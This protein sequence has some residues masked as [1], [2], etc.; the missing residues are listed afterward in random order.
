MWK[1]SASDR[2]S[3]WRELRKN[4]D[5]VPRDQAIDLVAEF[6]RSCPYNAY[7]LDPDKPHNWPD[8]WTLVEENYWC[9]LAKSLGMLY[10]IKLTTHNPEVEIRVYNDPE[11]RVQYNLVWIEQGKYILNMND[12]A[13][14]NKAQVS[15]LIIHKCYGPAELKLDSY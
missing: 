8:P 10:T 9:D 15:K 4:L 2:L 11:S 6:W 5:N 1:L 3:R 12:Q 7:Y 14:V 13:V